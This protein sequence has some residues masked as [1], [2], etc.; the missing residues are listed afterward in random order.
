MNIN[1]LMKAV[2]TI[3]GYPCKQDLYE[4]KENKFI[5]F[6]Y[7]DE[8]AAY[9]ADNDEEE[10]TVTITVQLIT[11]QNYNYLSDKSKLKRTLK[12]QGFSVEDIQTLLD[13]EATGTDRAR[14]TIYTCNYTGADN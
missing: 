7:A 14:R 12:D 9:Y 1:P 13:D 10:I 3:M 2:G 8:R 5:V 11:P 4:G 6:S